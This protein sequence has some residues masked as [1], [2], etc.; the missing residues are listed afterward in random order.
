MKNR[1]NSRR[2]AVR[3]PETQLEAR[4]KDIRREQVQF[5]RKQRL[6]Q[7]RL[8]AFLFD[9]QRDLRHSLTTKFSEQDVLLASVSQLKPNDS[10]TQLSDSERKF[11]LVIIYYIL[12]F[13]A[14]FIVPIEVSLNFF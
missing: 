1:W 12:L 8:W 3:V 9:S 11:Y 10:N 4:L 13:I 2:L 5:V 14:I 6:E 7:S